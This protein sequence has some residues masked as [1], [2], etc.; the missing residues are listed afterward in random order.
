MKTNLAALAAAL[1][2]TSTHAIATD[3]IS[4]SGKVQ[5]IGVHGTDKVMLNVGAG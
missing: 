1:A 2:L 3:A 5:T 4:C